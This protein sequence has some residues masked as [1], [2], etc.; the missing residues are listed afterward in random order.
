MYRG[1]PVRYRQRN[2]NHKTN[3]AVRGIAISRVRSR[4][5]KRSRVAVWIATGF[6]VFFGVIALSAL[7]AV[8]AVATGLTFLSQMEAQLPSVDA[9]EELDFAEPSVVYDRTGTIELARVKNAVLIPRE[10]VSVASQGPYVHVRGP[11]DVDLVPVKLGRENDKFVEVTQ[12]LKPGD[13][14][15]VVKAGEKEEKS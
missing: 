9:F 2:G 13:R 15:L 1:Q 4:P 6:A 8:L 11:F 12:G 10:A 3:G 5:P 14:V 7:S